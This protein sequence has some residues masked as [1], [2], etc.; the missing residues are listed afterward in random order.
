M[1]LLVTGGLGFIGSNF[2]RGYLARHPKDSIVNLDLCTYAG[3]PANLDGVRGGP[4]YAEIR[5]DIA[6][7]R[8]ASRAMK[9]AA[10]V[11]HFAA[12]SHVDR[13]IQGSGAFLRTNAEGTRVLLEAAR[14]EGVERFLHVSTDEVYGSVE[15][16]HSKETDRLA[17][18]SPYAASK[19]ASD[20]LALS[21]FVTHKLP[22]LVTRASNNYGPRQH[23]EKALPLMVTNWLEGLPYPLYGDGK[24]VRDWLFVEDHCRAIELILRKGTPGEVYNVGGER[25]CRNLELV[26]R[27]R[28]IMGVSADLVRRVPDRPGHD[29]RYALDCSKLRKLGFKHSISFDEGLRRTVDWYRENRDWWMRTKR[30]QSFQNYYRRQYAALGAR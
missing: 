3:N 8:A 13:S 20:L 15:R 22:V 26:E 24:N 7:A 6:D 10:A 16:G 30:A 19:A 9:G 28:A 1:K 4:R 11:V 14:A 12:E 23:P 25:S 17:P 5:G 27:V 21:Y 29:R 18:R 2:I